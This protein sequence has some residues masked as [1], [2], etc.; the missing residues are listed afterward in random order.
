[1]DLRE[2]MKDSPAPMRAE[3]LRFTEDLR[4]I[5][6]SSPDL[7]LVNAEVNTLIATRVE[8]VIRDADRRANG[9]LQKKW[10]KS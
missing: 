9:L 2:K 7:D 10:R 3:M 8:P 1:M 4:K 5:V 6:E